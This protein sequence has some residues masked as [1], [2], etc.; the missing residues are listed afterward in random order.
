[1]SSAIPGFFEPYRIAG[2]DYVDGD[3][4]HT[5]HADLAVEHRAD[6]IVVVN[7]AVPLKV[8]SPEEGAVRERGLYAI[9]EQAGHLTRFNLPE[10]GLRE[11]KL[12]HPLVEFNMF[13]H[14]PQPTHL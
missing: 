11:L 1:A 6:L 2:R 10:L 7:P 9:M 12:R 4:G 5:G 14:D 3:V 13:L 8:G